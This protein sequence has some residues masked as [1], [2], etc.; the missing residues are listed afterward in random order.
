MFLYGCESCFSQHGGTQIKG[1]WLSVY[2]YC[3]IASFPF[4]L[5]LALSSLELNLTKN[6]SDTEL[7]GIQK[8]QSSCSEFQILYGEAGNGS[9]ST[10]TSLSKTFATLLCYENPNLFSSAPQIYA[11]TTIHDSVI[12]C[13]G[14]LTYGP[15]NSSYSLRNLYQ[16]TNTYCC[17]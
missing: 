11:Q 3:F 5:R 8:G 1:V 15:R 2:Y 9:F 14:L 16:S 17:V 4:D 10:A 7:Y 12:V 13:Q 6:R